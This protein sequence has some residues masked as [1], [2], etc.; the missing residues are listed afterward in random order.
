MATPA[1]GWVEQALF[2]AVQNATNVVAIPKLVVHARL[3]MTAR[4]LTCSAAALS[5]H[6]QLGCNLT[7]NTSHCQLGVVLATYTAVSVSNHSHASQG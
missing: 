5:P 6:C 3:L 2:G 1:Q 4:L 7:N